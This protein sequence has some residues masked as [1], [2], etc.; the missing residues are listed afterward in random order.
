MRE[1]RGRIMGGLG[2]E[3]DWAR[4]SSGL[5]GREYLQESA[6]Q[7]SIP[8]SSLVPSLKTAAIHPKRA[9]GGKGPMGKSGKMPYLSWDA[10]SSHP[11]HA[12]CK[13]RG[14]RHCTHSQTKVYLNFHSFA[15]STITTFQISSTSF[16]L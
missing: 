15:L 13:G 7:E 5:G 6:C 4:G 11:H 8:P 1:A 2:W 12:V 9:S 14:K 3:V 16:P 10:W